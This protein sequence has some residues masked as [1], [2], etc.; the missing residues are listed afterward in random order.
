MSQLDILLRR[1]GPVVIVL[2]VPF[3]AILVVMIVSSWDTMS[4]MTWLAVLGGGA[5]SVG[6]MVAMVLLTVA[7]YRRDYSHLFEEENEPDA[8]STGERAD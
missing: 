2:C 1:F 5:G 6:I 3:L 4:P 8:T 7:A